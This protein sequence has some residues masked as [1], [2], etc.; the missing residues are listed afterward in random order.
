MDVKTLSTASA[1][2]VSRLSK[3][4][5]RF[6]DRVIAQDLNVFRDGTQDTTM[7][8]DVNLVVVELDYTKGS[9]WVIINVYTVPEI[10]ACPCDEP[11]MAQK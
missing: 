1:G 3:R 10:R 7:M 4:N 11:T 2:L 6:V 8:L 9:V 5:I